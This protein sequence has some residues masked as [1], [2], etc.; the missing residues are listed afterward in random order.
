MYKILTDIK[1]TLT[2]IQ[3]IKSLKIGFEKGADV[4]ANCPLVR[5]IPE[6]SEAKGIKEDLTIQIAIAFDLKNNVEELYKQFYALEKE[7]KNAMELIPYKCIHLNTI[8]DEDK[9]ST[10]KAGIIR[11]KVMD[12]GLN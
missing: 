5:I 4:S 12:I 7:I 3:T 8:M 6:G 9:L 11:F 2:N 1:T 10:L